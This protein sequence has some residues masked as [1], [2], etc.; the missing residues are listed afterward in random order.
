MVKRRK[1]LGMIDREM[2]DFIAVMLSGDACSV[3]HAAELSG[4]TRST[5]YRWNQ[6][7]HPVR[8]ELERR[9]AATEAI[10]DHWIATLKDTARTTATTRQE[11]TAELKKHIG[12]TERD[13]N[14]RFHRRIERENQRRR[15]EWARDHPG[16]VEEEEEESDE[17]AREGPQTPQGRV[18]VLSLVGTSPGGPSGAA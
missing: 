12:L 11:I 16:G 9:L 6:P 18:P 10:V 17:D 2:S 1:M 3:A 7:G 5:A 15:A 14:S 4:V 13:Q 8:V